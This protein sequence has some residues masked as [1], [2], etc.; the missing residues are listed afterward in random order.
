MLNQQAGMAMSK[1]HHI[2]HYGELVMPGTTARGEL[3]EDFTMNSPVGIARDHYD[4]VWVCDTGNSRLLVFTADLNTLLHVIDTP[5]E[6]TEQAR[7]LPIS[8][9]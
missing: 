7:R 2:T 1:F 5:G 3:P 9:R 4:H 8:A 6:G